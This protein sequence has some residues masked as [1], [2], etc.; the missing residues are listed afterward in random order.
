MEVS[1]NYQGSVKRKYHGSVTWEKDLLWAE[2]E[3]DAAAG[4]H[5]CTR[6][7]FLDAA[8]ALP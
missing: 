1:W 7:H 2:V 4:L 5:L 8:M 3:V 6:R